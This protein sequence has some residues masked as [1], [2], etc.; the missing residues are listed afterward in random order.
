MFRVVGI[1]S[2]V[3]L[4]L[5]LAGPTAGAPLQPRV[6]I[7]VGPAGGLTDLYR[8]IGTRA[9]REAHRWTSNVVRV[10]SP[11][12]TWPVVRRALQGASIVVYLGHGNGWPSR[13][14]HR[15]DPATEDGLGLNPVGGAGDVAHR[16]YGE[17]FLAREIHLAPGATL[18]LSHLC[19][20]SGNS[21]PGLPE[22]TFAVGQQRV[23]NHAAGWIRAGAGAVIADTFGDPGEY[24]RAVLTTN[25]PIDRIWREAAN[26]QGHVRTFPSVR[27]AG[28]LAAMDPTRPSSGF[29]R[30]LV[31]RPGLDAAEVRAGAAS[32][33]GV[34]PG[35]LRLA[36]SLAERGV[37]FGTPVLVPSG[38]PARGLVAGLPAR[39]SVPMSTPLDRPV[40][41]R[42][43]LSLRWTL[44]ETGPIV[45][46]AS[47]MTPAAES[48]VAGPPIAS[49][50]AEVADQTG[51]AD[52]PVPTSRDAAGLHV[53]VN[54][55]IVPGT[56]LVTI[57]VDDGRGV[58]FDR[59]TQSLI[60]P[61][62]VRVGSALSVSYGVGPA[63]AVGAGGAIRSLVRVFNDG[64]LAWADPPPRIEPD[65]EPAGP[66]ALR[67]P[68]S[69]QLIG[70]WLPLDPAPP[71]EV[72]ADVAVAVQVDPGSDRVAILDLIAPDAP[73][74]YLLIL[75]I[76]S[77]RRGS[78]A[79]SGSP[80][81][82]IRVTV[83]P[84]PGPT[85]GAP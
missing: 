25:R 50:W 76:V 24:I 67:L 5:V 54:L 46:P 11:D 63:I 51:L 20:A 40:S 55:P 21:E 56:Y 17:T 15:L 6:A 81:G 19:Y 2:A 47:P 53:V 39:L 70:H 61:I 45:D 30:S 12:A 26:A 37:G 28:Y 80:I 34:D 29:H 82:Q 69:A 36:L 74:S 8:S 64:A 79:A 71:I 23:D 38:P 42:L 85:P 10:E 78:L 13:Y 59:A 1:V 7:I 62:V 66:F 22:G 33:A 14:R 48:P 58:P 60:P 18:I 9:D 75:D 41:K 35:R 83:G 49:P 52:R 31:W 4:F 73:G 65:Q 27:S 32:A 43:G 84:A 3:A 68:P 57:T 77:P 44:V 72:P 16:Y